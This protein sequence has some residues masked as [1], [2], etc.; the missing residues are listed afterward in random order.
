MFYRRK[1]DWNRVAKFKRQ[2]PLSGDEVMMFIV[3]IAVFGITAGAFGM[4][5]WATWFA[6]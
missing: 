2:G 3:V 4:Y 5:R 1:C 6:Q